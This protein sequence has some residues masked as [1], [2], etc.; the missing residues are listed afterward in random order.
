MPE[1]R[2]PS[3]ARNG[4]RIDST[5]A[6]GAARVSMYSC[7]PMWGENSR[8]GKGHRE[9]LNADRPHCA[10]ADRHLR[11]V[12][13]LRIYVAVHRQ[14]KYFSEIAHVYVRRGQDRFTGVL[15]CAVV[16]I[17]L[18]EDRNLAKRV[19]QHKLTAS[20]PREQHLPRNAAMRFIRKGPSL[21]L[22]SAS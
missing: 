11:Q 6:T 10:S 15:A 4:F 14:G 17:V 19:T 21:S 8:S 5:I 9:T 7:L 13:W 1:T 22:P 12:Q 3:Q 16:V 18:R 20:K 2:E